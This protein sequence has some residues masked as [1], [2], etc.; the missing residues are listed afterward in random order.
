MIDP[1]VECCEGAPVHRDRRRRIA[2]LQELGRRGEW[3][4]LYRRLMLIEFPREARMGWQLAILRTAAAPRMARILAD[5]GH[6]VENPTKRAYDTGLIIYELVHGGPESERGRA[7][8]RLMNRSHHGRG[9]DQEDLTY[10]LC[11]MIVA[12]FRYIEHAGWR[13]LTELELRSG[14][15]YWRDIGRRMAIDRLPDDYAEAEWLFDGYEARH[16]APSPEGS[17]IGDRMITALRGRLPRPGRPIARLVFVSQLADPRVIT[18]LG[19]DPASRPVQ[20]IADTAARIHG[21]VQRQRRPRTEPIFTP[22]QKAGSIYPH[23]YELDQLG[24]G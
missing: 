23:G 14:V 8:I 2:E 15:E 21:L 3:E 19:L 18:A 6:F 20:R 24:P 12:A 1:E 9:I 11:A 22:G 10:V 17:L 16:I 13:S 5:A 7:M 4:A